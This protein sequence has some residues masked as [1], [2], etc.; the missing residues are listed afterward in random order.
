LSEFLLPLTTKESEPFI[1]PDTDLQQDWAKDLSIVTGTSTQ[2]YC[3]TS[4]YSR[5]LHNATGSLVWVDHQSDANAAIHNHNKDNNNKDNNNIQQE[6]SLDMMQF[7]NKIRR[8]TPREL[9]NLFGFSKDFNFPNDMTLEHQY[10][11][12]GNSVNVSVISVLLQELL[13]PSPDDARAI[14]QEQQLQ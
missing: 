13:F 14:Q 10:K 11:L 4:G 3:F 7:S 9:L 12:I 8:F 6:K 2:T 5:V 1:I